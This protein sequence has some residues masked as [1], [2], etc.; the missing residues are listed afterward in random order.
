MRYNYCPA[1]G[2]WPTALALLPNDQP[3]S[4]AC[5]GCP[6]RNPPRLRRRIILG[7]A[8]GVDR[9]LGPLWAIGGQEGA[10]ISQPGV[11]VLGLQPSDALDALALARLANQLQGRADQVGYR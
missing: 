6:Y 1:V 8:L 10:K 4:D 5:G 7:R 9:A 11:T 3:I 2:L